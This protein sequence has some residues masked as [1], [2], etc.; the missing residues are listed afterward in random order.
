MLLGLE[1]IY[2]KYVCVIYSILACVC[3]YEYMYM[4]Y[5]VYVCIYLCVYMYC[6]Y[7]CLYIHIYVNIYGLTHIQ[8]N[9]CS[10]IRKYTA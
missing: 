3:L 7:M 5:A 2:C 9:K 1:H 6:V 10:C 4:Q 8:K